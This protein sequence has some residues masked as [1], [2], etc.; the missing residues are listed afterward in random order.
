MYNYFLYTLFR[1]RLL[2]SAIEHK[3]IM[4]LYKYLILLFFFIIINKWVEVRF[5][6][7]VVR[8]KGDSR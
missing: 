6:R 1:F 8:Q 2:Y 5:G 4:T 3:V 7:G